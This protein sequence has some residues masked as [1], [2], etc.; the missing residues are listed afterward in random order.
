MSVEHRSTS[1]Q[2][3]FPR[4][5][6]VRH[7]DTS[8]RYS[9]H[10]VEELDP[11]LPAQGYVLVIDGH[12][13][14]LRH[15]DPA[16]LH[17]GRQ[18]VEQL[19]D[20]SGLLPDVDIRDRPDYLT[21]GYMLD[22]SRDRVPTRQTLDRLVD[23]LEKCRYNHLQLYVEHTFAYSGHE[24]VW[25]GA[26]PLDADDLRWLRDR[27]AAAG[28]ELAANQNCFGHFERWLAYDPYRGRAEC[29]E[30]YDLVSGVHFPPGVLAPTRDNAEFVLRLV[31]EQVESFRARI[32]NIG[33]DETFELGWGVS[34][35]NVRE[36]G[37]TAVYFEHLRRIIE[38]LVDDG[39]QVQFWGDV[40]AGEP[41]Y[42]E[43]APL[44]GATVL[45]WNYDAP[46]IP[47]PR[48]SG[49]LAEILASIGIDHDGDRHFAGRL[50][51]FR[52]GGIRHWV[53]PGTSTWRSIV[54]RLDNA[55][56][57]LEDAARAGRDSGAEGFLLTD[58]GDDGHHQP[59]T[60]S[61][62]AL[63]YGGAL[64]WGID[65]NTGLDVSTAIDRLLL[66]DHAGIMGGV[67]DRIGRAASRT[68]VLAE[69]ASPIFS[70]LFPH[71]FVITDGSPDPEMVGEVIGMFDSSLADL[72]DARPTCIQGETLVEE[73]V[74]AIELARVGAVSM[75]TDAG[76]DGPPEDERA[77]LSQDL[78]DR[79]RAAW[80]ATSREGGLESSIAH[81]VNTRDRLLGAPR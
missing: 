17:H 48:I 68:G 27:C 22:V 6:E 11:A 69:N 56:A 31:R 3:L 77:A 43:T 18:T 10:L 61:Y 24:M 57:N 32:V 35:R 13:A 76:V 50:R 38:P 64:A 63:A 59:L 16:G 81:L 67:L 62:P 30:G 53:V 66:G 73:L 23:V 80:L 74:V 55:R 12:Q 60:V 33:C 15:A 51:P 47:R 44:D 49:P 34:E 72:G 8:V 36:R 5:H 65:A 58:W 7:L 2:L 45:V 25:G 28:I 78:I 71:L 20:P 1:A 39:L 29:P 41:R 21:R 75:A 79:Y 52:D 19:R 37:R 26:S 40:I 14:V 9:H 42:L 4:P 54:G 70:A 46:G